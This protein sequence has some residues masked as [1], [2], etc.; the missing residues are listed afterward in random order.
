MTKPLGGWLMLVQV[1]VAVF[2]TICLSGWQITRGM[3]KLDLKRQ[4]EKTFSSPALAPGQWD[5]ST[6]DYSRVEALG[7]FNEKQ[8]FLLQ[9]RRY[10]GRPGYWVIGVFHTAKNSFLVNRGWV[11]IPGNVRQTP[12]FSTP[13]ETI[14]I[15]GVKWPASTSAVQLKERNETWPY[16]FRSL[17]VK[18]MAELAQS[19][20]LEI[21]LLPGSAGVLTPAP[22]EVDF[23][24]TKHWG[25]AFQWL[26]IGAAIIGGYWYFFLRIRTRD[27]SSP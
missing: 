14:R 11:P 2:V 15:Q 3:E 16:R 12:V 18:R 1:C 27:S 19:K 10:Q 13:R 4:H 25:Y 7:K 5:H 6:P 22:R 21:R 23:S 17:N 26:L 9:N 8:F 20:A 24:T